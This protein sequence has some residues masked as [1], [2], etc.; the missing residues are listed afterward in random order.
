MGGNSRA[1][2]LY[3]SSVAYLEDLEFCADTQMDI[4]A[5]SGCYADAY[6]VSQWSGNPAV[7]AYG[8]VDYPTTYT[9]CTSLGK[10]SPP[11]LAD[12]GFEDQTTLSESLDGMDDYK[13]AAKDIRLINQDMHTEAK[14][15][16]SV[17]MAKYRTDFE[18]PIADLQNIVQQ[19]PDKKAGRLSL[20]KIKH[21]WFA[22]DDQDKF[23][24]YVEEL[25]LDKSMSAIWPN[26]RG[27]LIPCHLRKQEYQKAIELTDQLMKEYPKHELVKDWLFGKA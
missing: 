20:A 19:H 8:D 26:A 21:T 10:S 17:D 11:D 3:T 1:L 15:Q 2:R 6:E 18:P 27:L 7:M 16:G 22:T 23:A 9:V 14:G 24:A 12:E 25:L 5:T 4:Y 13:A